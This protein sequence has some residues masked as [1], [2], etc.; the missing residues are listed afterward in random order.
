[1][2]E[3]FAPWF[4]RR[5]RPANTHAPTARLSWCDEELQ[6]LLWNEGAKPQLQVELAG[7]SGLFQSC[8][9]AFDPDNDQLLIDGL[10]PV[11]PLDLIHQLPGF[12][13]T[14]FKHQA[15][16]QL[17]VTLEQYALFHGKPALLVRIAQK[18]FRQDR[19]AHS[20]VQFPRG[21]GPIALLQLPMQ[22]QLRASLV[23]VSRGGLRLNIFGKHNDPWPQHT[24]IACQ[25]H[26]ADHLKLD[27]QL[28]LKAV[29][30]YRSPCQ[31]TQ[32]RAK[33]AP[34]T[35]QQQHTL[36]L[37]LFKQLQDNPNAWA[38]SQSLP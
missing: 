27:C 35:A 37:F 18:T 29:Q 1:M 16:L 5:S 2:F 32:V 15:V 30:Y 25:L 24:P 9:L 31:H 33:F 17:W 4:S 12:S 14:L 34:M 26:L 7:R 38:A 28:Q 20:R 36:H 6:V 13:I 3:R 11:P 10:F 19:R 23:N 8:L 22:P 21:Q